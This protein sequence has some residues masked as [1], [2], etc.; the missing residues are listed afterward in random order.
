MSVVVSNFS[1]SMLSNQRRSSMSAVD[2]KSSPCTIT[3][4]SRSWCLNIHSTGHS[5][6]TVAQ[7]ISVLTVPSCEPRAVHRHCKFTTHCFV[8][9]SSVLFAEL[10]KHWRRAGCMKY[11]RAVSFAM[12]CPMFTF[13]CSSNCGSEDAVPQ[14]FRWRR[15]R[16]SLDHCTL[17]L[18]HDKPTAVLGVCF[19][20]LVCVNPPG[21]FPVTPLHF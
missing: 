5:E 8:L 6:S 17:E 3:T 12:M 18:F 21:I 13:S 7:H 15:R 14:H 9:N 11:A 1:L 2:T 19:A 4:M 16:E 20:L 10:H